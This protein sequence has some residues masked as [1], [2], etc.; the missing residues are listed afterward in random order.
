LLP[1]TPKPHKNLIIKGMFKASLSAF[2]AVMCNAQDAGLWKNVKNEYIDFRWQ[3]VQSTDKNVLDKYYWE[4]FMNQTTN[5]N[6]CAEFFDKS[7]LKVP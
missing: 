2:F 6:A 5:S 7:T 3:T 4:I 1:K